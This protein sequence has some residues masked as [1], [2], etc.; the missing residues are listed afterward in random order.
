MKAYIGAVLAMIVMGGYICVVFGGM[1]KYLLEM[2][3]LLYFQGMHIFDLLVLVNHLLL[4]YMEF[5]VV[6]I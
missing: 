2:I 6:C 1:V 4:P 5:F 3:F